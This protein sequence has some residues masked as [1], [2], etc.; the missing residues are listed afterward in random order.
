MMTSMQ[1]PIIFEPTY[2]ATGNAQTYT[3]YLFTVEPENVLYLQ[4][5]HR[6]T[7]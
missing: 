7:S 1:N 5:G 2:E 3:S 4:L 6:L